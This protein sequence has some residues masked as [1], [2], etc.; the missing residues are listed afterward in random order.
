M[1]EMDTS[2]IQQTMLAEFEK[3]QT[4]PLQ[5]AL[6]RTHCPTLLKHGGDAE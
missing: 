2:K 6:S 1:R 5:A 4:T 3:G